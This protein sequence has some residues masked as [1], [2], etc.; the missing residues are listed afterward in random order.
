MG[1]PLSPVFADIVMQEL[2]NAVLRSIREFSNSNISF[3]DL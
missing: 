3:T 2:D 1:S